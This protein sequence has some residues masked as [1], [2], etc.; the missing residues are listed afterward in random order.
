MSVMLPQLGVLHRFIFCFRMDFVW[1]TIIILPSAH[2]ISCLVLGLPLFTVYT[3]ITTT[4]VM[5][6]LTRV[7]QAY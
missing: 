7:Y 5:R 3:N 4:A 1:I 2:I 6:L